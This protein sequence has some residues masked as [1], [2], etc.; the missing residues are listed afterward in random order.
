MVA[1]GAPYHGWPGPSMGLAAR[2]KDSPE[3]ALVTHGNSCE[4]QA[5]REMLLPGQTNVADRYYGKDYQLLAE[6]NHAG[7]FF[8]FRISDSAVI[9]SQQELVSVSYTHLTLPTSD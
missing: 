3:D 5:L 7:A 2:G 6:I 1:S 9:N 4:A 8:V